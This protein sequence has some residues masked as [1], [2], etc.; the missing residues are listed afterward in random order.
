ML[1]LIIQIRRERSNNNQEERNVVGLS[2]FLPLLKQMGQLWGFYSLFCR[3]S[4][5]YSVICEFQPI[6]FGIRYITMK[7]ERKM[8]IYLKVVLLITYGAISTICIGWLIDV[9]GW[10]NQLNKWL[11]KWSRRQNS[12]GA[13]Q[14]GMHAYI[15][16]AKGP[17]WGKVCFLCFSDDHTVNVKYNTNL[18]VADLFYLPQLATTG[19]H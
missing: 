11:S 1:Q 6:L 15:Q 8:K 13:Q 12:P 2:I 18:Q 19:Y 17:R 3:C 4:D 10:T 7:F 14:T 5:L 16:R 9:D